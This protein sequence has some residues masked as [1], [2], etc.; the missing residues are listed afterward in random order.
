MILRGRRGVNRLVK[1]FLIAVLPILRC[2]TSNGQDLFVLPEVGDLSAEHSQQSGDLLARLEVLE[3]DNKILR[4]EVTEL[5]AQRQETADQA[6]Y[7][8]SGGDAYSACINQT[9]GGRSHNSWARLEHYSWNKAGGWK[10][11]PFGRLRGEAIY[12]TAPQTGDAVIVLLNPNN[13]G[14]DEDQATVHGKQSAVNF[15]ITGPNLDGWQTGGLVFMNFMGAQPLRNFSGAN[16]VNAYGEIKNQSW[17]IAVGRMF[18]LFSP[19][20]PTTVNQIQQRGAGNAGIY[21]GVINID[22]YFTVSDTRRW[23]V[24]ARISQQDISDFSAIPQIRGKDNGWPNVESR[25]G[26]ELGSQTDYG[27]PMEIGLSGFIGE[28]QAVADPLFDQGIILPALDEVEQAGGACVDLQL[29]G[30]KFGFRGEAWW[31]Q[32][33]G[34][35]F[36][37]VLQTLNPQTGRAL[38]S[39]GGWGEIYYRFDRPVSLHFGYGLDDPKNNDLGF[40]DPINGVGQIHYNQ[41]AWGNII[42]NVTDYLELSLEVSHRRTEYLVATADNEG[43]LVHFG[44]S[45]NF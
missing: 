31:G 18:D 33:A 10:V 28:T 19:I 5:K 15:A 24:S 2:H 35:Y 16:I 39:V 32:A 20:S 3:T 30:R 25:V 22:R 7:W 43:T 41:V 21:R 1:L 12:S 36:V 34:T 4:S 42:W 11:V 9:S 44:S 29:N 26:L 6:S 27:R 23:T 17:R 40:L 14:I 37:A 13:P 8:E 38:E 45:L